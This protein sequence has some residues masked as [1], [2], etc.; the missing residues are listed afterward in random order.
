[1]FLSL[2]SSLPL[3]LS[4]GLVMRREGQGTVAQH[5]EG[6]RLFYVQG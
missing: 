1:M 3:S 5:R 2:P 4:L 6:S